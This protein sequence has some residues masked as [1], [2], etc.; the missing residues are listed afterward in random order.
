[1]SP[2]SSPRIPAHTGLGLNQYGIAEEFNQQIDSLIN[3]YSLSGDSGI[4]PTRIQGLNDN[5][6]D[7]D[8]QIAAMEVRMTAEEN[9]LNAQF[10]AMES[11]LSN[12]QAWGNQL[13]AGLGVSTSSSSH[14]HPVDCFQ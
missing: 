8:N 10:T 14:L 5:M 12:T 11:T 1:M 2:P 4:I 7:I 9:S 3:A 13:L 6:T